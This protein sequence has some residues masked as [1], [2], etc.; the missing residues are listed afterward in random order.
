M[1]EF[2]FRFI[3][4]QN[5]R[6]IAW[7]IVWVAIIWLFVVAKEVM[8]L[9]LVSYAIAILIDPLVLRLERYGIPRVRSVLLIGL[10]LFSML[11]AFILFAIPFLIRE[12]SHLVDVLPG[13]LAGAT[14]RL[15]TFASEHFNI[16]LPVTSEEIWNDAREYLTA[17]DVE[18]LKA[19]G[20]RV[21][22][23][24]LRG[25]S[26]TLTVLNLTLLPFFVFYI[27]CDLHTL[28]RLIGRYVD[29]D[30]EVRLKEITNEILRHVYAFLQGQLTVS[31]V[32]AVLYALGL[33]LVGLPSGIMVGLVAGLF[34]FVP[35]LGIVFGISI[36]SII[37]LV[38][39]F[40]LWKLALVWAVFGV[41]HIVS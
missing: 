34:N 41:V 2:R 40:T 32:M 21:A 10:V 9:L 28:H 4:E 20:Q 3:V 23:T 16:T 33:W 31:V 27:S 7:L 11:V 22:E 19:V 8:T 13:Y 12:Y 25:Y 26:V 17:V 6:L 14:V 30:I 37:A 35:Y 1:S 38:T 24:L 36:A 39:G 29:D 15:T 18:Q 5:R